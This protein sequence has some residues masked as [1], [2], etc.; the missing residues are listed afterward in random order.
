MTT[1]RTVLIILLFPLLTFSVKS[2]AYFQVE[3]VQYRLR[4]Q[5]YASIHGLY[6]AT[7]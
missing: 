1:I 4:W 3:S 6:G 7:I 5:V 2:Q